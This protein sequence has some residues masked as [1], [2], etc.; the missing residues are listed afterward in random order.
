MIEFE[1]QMFL[2]ILNDDGLVITAKGIGLESV[3]INL[4][5]VYNDNG[6]LVLVL[7]TSDKEEQYFIQELD[8]LGVKPLPRLLTS[9]IGVNERY[10]IL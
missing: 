5:K 2:D 6:N 3:F 8:S 7:G 4:L 1:N 9:E 10:F